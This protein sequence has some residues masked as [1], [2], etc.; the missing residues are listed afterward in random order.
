MSTG[1]TMSGSIAFSMKVSAVSTR[2]IY[3]HGFCLT[4]S[5]WNA[6]SDL[7]LRVGWLRLKHKS[8]PTSRMFFSFFVFLFFLVF[9]LRNGA[10]A[11]EGAVS[12]NKKRKKKK[13]KNERHRRIKNART[14]VLKTHHP[15]NK[16]IH[17]TD[18]LY[19]A[20]ILCLRWSLY[21]PYFVRRRRRFFLLRNG[22]FGA[23]GAA[24]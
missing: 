11:A 10:F 6:N 9:Y 5:F 7:I 15:T 13:A 12:Y 14:T 3:A 1:D 23:E 16:M 19:P 18:Q 8:R 4:L 2:R 24:S 17:L 21:Y 22:A 20:I